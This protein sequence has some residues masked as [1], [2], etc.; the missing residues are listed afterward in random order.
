[1]LWTCTDLNFKFQSPKSPPPLRSLFR[2]KGWKSIVTTCRPECICTEPQNR[3][4]SGHFDRII[5]QDIISVT[6][7]LYK[8]KHKTL[9]EDIKCFQFF[10]NNKLFTAVLGFGS[11]IC[12]QAARIRVNN[13]CH[14]DCL[15]FTPWLYYSRCRKCRQGWPGKQLDSWF[16]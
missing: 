6:T 13:I 16:G 12:S 14:I 7:C 15:N 3:Q 1:M 5:E 10:M 8:I 9:M 2:H 11:R 4:K